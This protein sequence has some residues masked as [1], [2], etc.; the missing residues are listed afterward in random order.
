MGCGQ[1]VPSRRH[2]SFYDQASEVPACHFPCILFV[3]V[4]QLGP[5]QGT[6]TPQSLLLSD[7]QVLS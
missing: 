3:R 4:S 7:L 2:A 5:S 6:V 1:T